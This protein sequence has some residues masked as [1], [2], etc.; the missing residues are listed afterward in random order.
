MLVHGVWI[1]Q[2]PGPKLSVEKAPKECRNTECGM[3]NRERCCS[4]GVQ[5]LSLISLIGSEC[6]QS[7][8]SAQERLGIRFA[9]PLA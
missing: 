9:P 7:S 4:W 6:Q 1:E 3:Q 5:M 2:G 8:S